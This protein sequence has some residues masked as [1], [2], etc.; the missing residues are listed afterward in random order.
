M[1]SSLVLPAP[2]GGEAPMGRAR[3][4]SLDAIKVGGERVG[5]A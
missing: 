5:A 1:A 3:R 2:A 4:F